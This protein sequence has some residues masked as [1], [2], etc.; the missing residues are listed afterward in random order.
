MTDQTIAISFL[1]GKTLIFDYDP[2]EPC[3]KFYKRVGK[4]IGSL[5]C[6]EKT[7][8]HSLYQAGKEINTFE[9][10]LLPMKS[11]INKDCCCNKSRELCKC[12]WIRAVNWALKFGQAFK[13]MGNAQ[14]DGT[15]R[16]ICAVCL[17][18]IKE[19][20]SGS[21]TNPLIPATFDCNHTFHRRC[22]SKCMTCP[23]CRVAL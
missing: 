20:T 13:Y 15:D 17:E 8:Y 9:N 23:L 11:L 21:L 4:D 18:Y 6:D 14:P 16:S 19:I 1:T 12:A 5:S 2:E 22:V 7:M 3:W 10:R